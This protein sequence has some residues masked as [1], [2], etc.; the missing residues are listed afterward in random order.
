M[1]KLSF[2]SLVLVVLIVQ[3]Q[4]IVYGF[5]QGTADSVHFDQVIDPRPGDALQAAK[6]AQE[7]SAFLGPEA[8]DLLQ[9]GRGARFPPPLAGACDRKSMR[10]VPNLLD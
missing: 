9:P 5:C 7:L 6:L 1:A 3:V 2:T 8:R 4:I 10:L